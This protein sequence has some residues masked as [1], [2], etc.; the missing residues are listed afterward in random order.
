MYVA[1]PLVGFKQ[2][3]SAGQQGEIEQKILEE[4]D[5]KLE[6]F[7]VSSFPRMGAKG[8]LRAV[9]TPIMDLNIQKAEKDG[10]NQNRKSLKLDFILHRGCYATVMLR[11][12]MKPDDLIEAGF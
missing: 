4:E 9:L 7:R 8:G 12:F 1:I 10:L 5:V 6:D 3:T 11:E 2:A